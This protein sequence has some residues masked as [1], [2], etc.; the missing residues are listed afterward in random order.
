MYV[1]IGLYHGGVLMCPI[2]KTEMSM[3]SSN[4]RWHNWLEFDIPIKNI[5]RVN[6]NN[7]YLFYN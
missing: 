5:P 3:G 7:K 2:V 6:I 4:P 1:E